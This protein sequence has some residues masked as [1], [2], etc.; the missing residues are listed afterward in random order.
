MNYLYLR[1]NRDFLFTDNSR[2]FYAHIGS[3]SHVA[4]LF[5]DTPGIGW[6]AELES[7]S[8]R[9]TLIAT[10]STT[11]ELLDAHPELFI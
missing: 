2:S 7:S 10:F 8:D 6:C 4:M 1:A 3:L 5:A 11:T 9:H